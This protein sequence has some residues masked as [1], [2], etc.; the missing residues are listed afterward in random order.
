M[1]IKVALYLWQKAASFDLKI[2]L[3]ARNLIKT[4]IE[5]VKSVQHLKKKFYNCTRSIQNV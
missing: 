1:Q 3:M 5:M 4:A 2:A